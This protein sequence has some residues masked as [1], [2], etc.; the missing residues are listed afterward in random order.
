VL[1]LAGEQLLTGG[2]PLLAAY[3]LVIGH[4]RL[5]SGCGTSYLKSA[6]HV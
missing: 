5:L 1:L 4:R 3:D 6:R 2:G